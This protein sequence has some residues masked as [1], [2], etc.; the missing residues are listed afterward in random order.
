[1]SD[2]E[3]MF[4]REALEHHARGQTSSHREVRLGVSW[5]EWLYATTLLLL[6][7]GIAVAWLARTDEQTTGPAVVQARNGTF[8][9]L[10]PAAVARDLPHARSLELELPAGPISRLRI[11]HA[12]V[13]AAT[14]R[15]VARAGLPLSDQPVILL[16]GRLPAEQRLRR[17][18]AAQPR[19]HAH[20]TAVLRSERVVDVFARQIGAMFGRTPSP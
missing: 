5:L 12:H 20:I 6:V 11:R 2:H 4:R 9:A 15:A 8:S 1:M 13:T 18:L 17:A 10:L 16:Q 19:L 7:A 14:R 3:E